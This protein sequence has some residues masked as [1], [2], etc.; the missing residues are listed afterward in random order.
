M[1]DDEIVNLAILEEE[2]VVLLAL[3][4]AILIDLL[5]FAGATT[6]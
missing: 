4:T 5:W 2:G 3:L 6:A 1:F